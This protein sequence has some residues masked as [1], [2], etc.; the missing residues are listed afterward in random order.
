MSPRLYLT[1]PLIVLLP[2]CDQTSQTGE[3]ARTAYD[4]CI[5]AGLSPETDALK[6]CVAAPDDATRRQVIDEETYGT[7]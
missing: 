6:R 4:Q 3:P 7:N 5:I 2:A 1:L